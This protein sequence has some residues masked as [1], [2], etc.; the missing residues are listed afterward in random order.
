MDIV[1]KLRLGPFTREDADQAITEIER[2]RSVL[3]WYIEN[4]PPEMVGRAVR[5]FGIFKREQINS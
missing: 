4:S 1:R 3:Y 5:Q 2:L